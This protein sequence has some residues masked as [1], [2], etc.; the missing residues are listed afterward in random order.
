MTFHKYIADSKMFEYDKHY[1]ECQQQ[2]KPFIKSKINPVHGNY[3]VT[4]DLMTC[5][6]VFSELE[7][8]EIKNLIKSE[9]VFVNSTCKNIFNE[10]TINEELILIDGVSSEHVD[11]ICTSIYDL[12]QKYHD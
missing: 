3:T 10:Y 2:N 9:I 12:S 11:F 8:N 6:Y 4:I 1:R 5:N 7:L